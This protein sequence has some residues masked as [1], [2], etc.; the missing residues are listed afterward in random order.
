MAK[1][2]DRILGTRSKK[3]DVDDY[4]ELDLKEYEGMMDDEP[5]DMYVR[6]AELTNLNTLTEIKSEIYNGNMVIVDISSV[7]NDKLL[8]DRAIKDLR[9]F[10]A[11]VRGDIAGLGDDQLIL[12]PTSIRIDRSKVVPGSY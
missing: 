2:T 12:T 1:L 9:Q 4:V 8:M 6:I 7:R 11:D 5:A 10:V 3:I